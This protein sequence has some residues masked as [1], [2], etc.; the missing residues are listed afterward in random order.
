MLRIGEFSKLAKTTVKT[1]RYY[2]KVGLLKPAFVDSTT[3]YRY[4]TEEQL[5]IM[6]RILMYKK[7]GMQNTDIAD[8]L[9]G[10]DPKD[11]LRSL[12]SR[13]NSTIEDMTRQIAEIDRML[14][15][16][17]QRIYT[18]QIKEIEAHKVF[19]CRGYIS[20]LEN[21]RAFA[22]TCAK[23]L[24]RTNPEVNYSVPD[25]CCVIYPGKDY[26]EKNIFIE[27]AQSVDRMGK[28]TP[29][30]KFKTLEPITAISVEHRG[31]Y[32]NLRN[33]YLFAVKWA[34]EHGFEVRCGARE[35]YIDGAWNCDNEEDWLTEVQLPVK[36]IEGGV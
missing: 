14:D 16:A 33:A 2:D 25:Y 31:S 9:S 27:Y 8:I 7:A 15:S 34:A 32:E 5:E 24:K 29:T 1:L 13:L 22:Q 18:A 10:S 21:I 3:S 30:L 11:A 36:K 20:G 26:R 35:R 23:E 4:Y 17:E 19:C 6:R 28:D 12:K